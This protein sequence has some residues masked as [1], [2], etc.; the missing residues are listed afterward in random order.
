MGAPYANNLGAALREGDFHIRVSTINPYAMNT[1]L[2]QHPNPIY[3]Q[4]VNSSGL[5]DTDP[6]FNAGIT[7]GRQLLANGLPPAM[8][9]DTAAQLAQMAEPLPN[10]VV[11]SPKEP[12][13]TKGANSDVETQLTAENRLSAV[14]F[15]C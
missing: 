15:G 9:G 12:L 7:A 2:A 13:A 10:V 8:V 11:A 1:A 3:T 14:P 4:P 5:S 6:F